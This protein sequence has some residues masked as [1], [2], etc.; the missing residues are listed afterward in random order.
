MYGVWVTA[1][2]QYLVA[3]G[4]WLQKGDLPG[5]FFLCFA[6]KTASGIFLVLGFKKLGGLGTL[7]LECTI[8]ISS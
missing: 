2:S 7:H 1:L 8:V 3:V 6:Q 5:R 4:V